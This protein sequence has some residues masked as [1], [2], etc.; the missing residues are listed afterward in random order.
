MRVEEVHAGTSG[1]SYKRCFTG[2]PFP[3]SLSAVS[4]TDTHT[5]PQ[6]PVPRCFAALHGSQP[7]GATVNPTGTYWSRG[8]RETKGPGRLTEPHLRLP[9]VKAVYIEHDFRR[10]KKCYLPRLG[11]VLYMFGLGDSQACKIFGLLC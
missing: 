9:V 2:N 6:P 8:P 11:L 1:P 3:S 5:T 10:G 7:I 4:R